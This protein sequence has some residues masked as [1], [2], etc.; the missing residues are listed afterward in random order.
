MTYKN[1]KKQLVQTLRSMKHSAVIDQ[2]EVIIIDDASDPEHRIE[3]ILEEFP[4]VKLTRIEQDQKTWKNP[5]IPYNMAFRM[6]KGDKIVI[7]NS[8]S[9]HVGDVLKFVQDNLKPNVYYSFCCLSYPHIL[10][11]KYCDTDY[12]G[13]G[14]MTESIN[15]SKGLGQPARYDG[16][17]GWYN[18]PAQWPRGLNICSASTASTPIATAWR[19]T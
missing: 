9:A 3:D 4:F 1:R 12:F 7:Q 14:D 15:I 5:C 11:E 8:E 18:H 17:L 10:T 6:A 16:E 2:A 19:R 13:K